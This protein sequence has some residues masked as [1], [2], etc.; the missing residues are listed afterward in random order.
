MHNEF[1]PVSLAVTA[2]IVILVLALRLR[3]VG[4][5]Q[6]LRIERLWLLPVVYAVIVAGLVV[7][8][9]PDGAAWLYLAVAFVLGAAIGWY[10]GKTIAITV[11][12]QTHALNQSTS[13]AGVIFLLLLI[14]VR[15]GLRYVAVDEAASWH[16]SPT[17]ILDLFLVL[18]LGIIAAQRVEMYLR[19]NRLLAAA[20]AAKAA[21][22]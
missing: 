13:V 7:Q 22:T 3:R 20:K 2:A 8:S 11:D 16:L 5:V 15:Y 17:T 10:R 1:S 9:P 19:A 12:P 4:R 21:G 18:A 14:V 6:P